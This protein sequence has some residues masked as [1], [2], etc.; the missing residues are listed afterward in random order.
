LL[1]R[2]LITARELD[3]C[4]IEQARTKEFFGV[5]LVRKGIIREKDLVEALG[6]QSGLPLVNL[7]EVYIDWDLALTYVTH[8]MSHRTFLPI[9]Q[10]DM[11]VTVAIANPLDVVTVSSMDMYVR[12]KRLRMVLTSP[13]D[14]KVFIDE[15]EKRHKAKMKTF[16][17]K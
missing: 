12:P 9:R 10:D 1:A 17:D 15:C 7:R 5:I 6:E 13:S 4:L 14:L 16:F 11:S 3:E 8:V 2:R